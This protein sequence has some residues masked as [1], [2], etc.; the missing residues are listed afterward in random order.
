MKIAKDGKPFDV[1]NFG[2]LSPGE[3]EVIQLLRPDGRRR[4]MA[5]M[6]GEEYAAMAE[7]LILSAEELTTGEVAIYARKIGDPEESEAVEIA[8][9]GPGDNSPIDCLIRVIKRKAEN[10]QKEKT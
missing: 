6:I 4:R 8:E 5:A 9:N 10:V 2:D 3:V 7:D 1:D